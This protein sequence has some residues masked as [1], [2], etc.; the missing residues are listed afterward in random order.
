MH[1]NHDKSELICADTATRDAMLPVV[2]RLRPVDPH[3]ATF[4]YVHEWMMY[5]MHLKASTWSKVLSGRHASRAQA[6]VGGKVYI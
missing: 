2:P 4:G 5:D 1:L 3:D 6:V